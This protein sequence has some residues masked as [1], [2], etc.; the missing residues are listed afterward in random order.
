MHAIYASLNEPLSFKFP[1]NYY[2]AASCWL[3][4]WLKYETTSFLILEFL[5]YLLLVV[6]RAIKMLR[7]VSALYFQLWCPR[8]EPSTR[9]NQRDGICRESILEH[10]LRISKQTP[11]LL[12]YVRVIGYSCVLLENQ[13]L[14][15]FFL[16][17]GPSQD[18]FL[19]PHIP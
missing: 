9:L 8:K 14:V 15:F 2:N 1:V 19:L 16:L 10:F 18:V 12:A 6:E 7:T 4:N 11:K 13:N 5:W 3:E 17:A